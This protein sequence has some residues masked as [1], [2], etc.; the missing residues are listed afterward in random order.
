MGR[1]VSP[2]DGDI[3]GAGEWNGVSTVEPPKAMI[4]QRS[5]RF[6]GGGSRKAL[7]VSPSA[8]RKGQNEAV[9]R[10]VN[11]RLEQKAEE[12][13]DPRDVERVPFLCEC[14]RLDCT[15]VAMLSLSE[16]ER[17]REDGRRGLAVP[18]HE[19]LSVER[20]VAANDRF[21]TTEKFG[22]AAQIFARA[23]PRS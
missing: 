9:F 16:Y 17:V 22:P 5:V 14:P 6:G 19:D 8:E 13:I 7:A 21:L 20:V 3:S 11:E 23:D 2:P 18:G 12:L 4:R 10:D 1:L 15:Q